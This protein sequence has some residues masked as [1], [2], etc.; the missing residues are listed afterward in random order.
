MREDQR[1]LSQCLCFNGLSASP[2][3]VRMTASEFG[4][5]RLLL[6]NILETLREAL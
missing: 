4:T 3:S 1:A 5:V 6:K 2:S